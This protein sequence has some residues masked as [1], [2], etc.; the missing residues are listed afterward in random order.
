MK[1]EQN[2]I[3][4]EL[5]EKADQALPIGRDFIPQIERK[6]RETIADIFAP[7]S[8]ANGSQGED[9]SVLAEA[10]FWSL[11]ELINNANKANNRWALLRKAL[12]QRIKKEHPDLDDGKIY[13]DV[14]Y[15]IEHSQD[16]MLKAYNL[17][18]LDLTAS[19]LK[20]IEMH[21]VN[22]FALSEK[23]NK[24]ID[25]TLRI[26]RKG[27]ARS[28]AMN[29]INNSA[30][31]VIDKK[32]VEFNLEKIK[33]DLMNSG[34]N[35]FETAVGLYDKAEDHAGG[36]FGAG[37]RSIVL[38]LKEGYKPFPVDIVYSRIIQYRSAGNNTIFSI[39][40]PIP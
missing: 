25:V 4:V 36:G 8:S 11:C 13:G 9:Y 22:S 35:P 24:K 12:Y 31:T 7:P 32:R 37:L 2:A 21:R 19:I 34:N 20:M 14:D 40:L 23:F 33:E 26:K 10:V 5:L 29:V 28:L 16:D 15:A 17:Q 27:D 3:S 18:N 38:F 1:T 6:I 39:E 30:I